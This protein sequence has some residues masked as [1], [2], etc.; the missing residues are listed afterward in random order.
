ML[1]KIINEETKEVLIMNQEEATELPDMVEME[2]EQGYDGKVYVKGYAPAESVEH[3][4][5]A[6]RQQRQARF[7][8]EADPLLYDWEESK[9]RGESSTEKKK[10]WLAKKNEIRQALPYISEADNGKD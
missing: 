7:A 5:E 8:A 4:N 9:A 1:T 2:I 6:I 3:K 10:A